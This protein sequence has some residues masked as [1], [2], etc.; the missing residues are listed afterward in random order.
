MIRQHRGTIINVA[1]VAAARAI[2]GAAAYSASKAGVVAWS[3]VLAEEVRGEGIRVGV[4]LPGAVATPLW[5]A[6]PNAPA[7]ERMLAPEDVAR[8]VMLMATLPSGAALEELTLLPA[9]GIL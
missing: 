3:R 7:R 6:V 2:P 8:V 4:L 9:G 1:S 5:D